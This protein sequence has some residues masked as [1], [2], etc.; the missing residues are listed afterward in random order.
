MFHIFTSEFGTFHIF[1]SE[2]GYVFRVWLV[3]MLDEVSDRLCNLNLPSLKVLNFCGNNLFF[4]LKQL[5]S[6]YMK[7]LVT[8]FRDFMY[9]LSGS[10]ISCNPKFHISAVTYI[11]VCV[12]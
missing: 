11:R 4:L 3:F 7:K 1:S 10:A 9:S 8:V 5:L 2:F 12:R 6:V